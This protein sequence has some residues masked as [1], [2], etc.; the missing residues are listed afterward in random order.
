MRQYV[1]APTSIGKDNRLGTVDFNPCSGTV[2]SA[3]IFLP[4]ESETFFFKSLS[5]RLEVHCLATIK[6]K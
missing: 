4:D 2:V 6:N 5:D 3:I 1:K